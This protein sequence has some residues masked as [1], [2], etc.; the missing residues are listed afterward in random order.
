MALTDRQQRFIEEYCVDYNATQAAI[1][2]GYSKKT[3]RQI[4]FENL[5]KPDIRD[6]VRARQRI[7]SEG[8]LLDRAEVVT[9]MRDV[10]HDRKPPL[11]AQARIQAAKLLGETLGMWDKDGAGAD[12]IGEALGR[13]AKAIERAPAPPPDPPHDA[14]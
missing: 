2:A 5:T 11:G 14:G 6:A 13:V 8:L 3:A 4:G 9:V 7:L 1:R 12:T 10:M